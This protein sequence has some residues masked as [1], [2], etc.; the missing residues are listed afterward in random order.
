MEIPGPSELILIFLI[1]ALLFGGK[2]IPEIMGSVAQGIK[3]FKRALETDDAHDTPGQGQPTQ[4]TA[5][6]EAKS[7]EPDKVKVESKL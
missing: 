6:I 7:E 3:T 1:V 5:R 2:K 4:P